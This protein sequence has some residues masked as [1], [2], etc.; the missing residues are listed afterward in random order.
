MLAQYWTSLCV[1]IRHR[2]GSATEHGQDDSTIRYGSTGQQRKRVGR[3]F[4]LG[5]SHDTSINRCN[6][7]TNRCDDTINGCNATVNGCNAK[8]MQCYKKWMQYLS[9]ERRRDA[10]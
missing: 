9:L 1:S 10:Y 8:W 6:D 3:C 4:S 5:R 7:T 2:I